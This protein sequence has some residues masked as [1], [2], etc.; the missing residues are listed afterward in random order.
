MSPRTLRW[1]MKPERHREEL[2]VLRGPEEVPPVK[3]TLW[4]RFLAWLRP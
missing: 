1:H 4:R 3:L 2:V